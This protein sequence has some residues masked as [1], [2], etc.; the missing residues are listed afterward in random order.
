MEEL[1]IAAREALQQPTVASI[2]DSA[3]SNITIPVD[4]DQLWRETSSYTGSDNAKSFENLLV[5]QAV[6][7]SQARESLSDVD[8]TAINKLYGWASKLALPSPV[9]TESTDD[10]SSEQRDESRQRSTLAI[11]VI[12]LLAALLP[13]KDAKSAQDA[14]IAM[15]SFSSETDAWATCEACTTAT[16]LLDEIVKDSGRSSFWKI[17]ESTL[18]DQIKP[19]FAKTK[20]PAITESGRK[21]F[22]PVPL[23][24]FDLSVFDS[25]TKPWKMDAVYITTVF[26][27]IVKQYQTTDRAYLEAHFPLL[28]PPILTLI[29]DDSLPFKRTGCTL[30]TQLLIPI[31]ESNSDILRRTNLSSVFEDAIRPCFHSLPTITP[32][33]DS[34]HLLSAA[35]PA[36]RSLLQISYPHPP[37]SPADQ[38]LSATTNTLRSHL[39]PSFHHIGS[40]TASANSTS[41]LSSFPHPRLSALLL[42]QIATTCTDLGIHTTKYLQDI[43]PLIYSTLS[44]PF[45]PAYPPLLLA[46]VSVARAVILNAYLR[47][48]RW[49]GEILGAVCSCWVYILEEEGQLEDTSA[50]RVPREGEKF[51]ELEKLKKELRGLVY[52]L[53]YA[54]EN[55]VDPGEDRGQ[56]EA[57]ERIAGELRTL[58]DADESLRGCLLG[59]IDSEDGTYFGLDS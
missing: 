55:P 18:K 36:L 41:T 51:M 28:I 54:L 23:P 58:V 9:F 5:A 17:I 2:P 31:R 42:N 1:R 29:D 8:K 25:E 48:W 43:V 37:Q 40:T 16:A 39:I 20:N 27:W 50:T 59:E 21:N 12:S 24:R 44:N 3:L 6:L 46:A 53:Q 14:I 47:I 11:S 57:K 45:G 49:R 32:E 13:V 56:R 52:L 7:S 19:L 15:A 35:Y 4:L 26:S 33:D 34:I 10:S 38:F 30:L 22:H